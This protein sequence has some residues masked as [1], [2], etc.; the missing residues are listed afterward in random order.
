MFQGCAA[1]GALSPCPPPRLALPQLP[2]TPT[3]LW[4]GGAPIAMRRITDRPAWHTAAH[5]DW[6]VPVGDHAI[7]AS[8][9]GWIARFDGATGT[10][11]HERT[12]DQ[13]FGGVA[14]HDL[15]Q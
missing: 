1:R 13:V 3:V 8:G 2:P 12:L 6:I 9:R 10:F 5:I 14:L 4:P 7:V 11:S 15:R